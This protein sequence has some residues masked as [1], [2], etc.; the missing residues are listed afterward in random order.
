MGWF[1]NAVRRVGDFIGD[2]FTPSYDNSNESP[3]IDNGSLQYRINQETANTINKLNAANGID[4]RISGSDVAAAAAAYGITMPVVSTSTSKDTGAGADQETV[5]AYS[6]PTTTTTPSTT[7]PTTTTPE[8]FTYSFL[9]GEEKA[10]SFDEIIRSANN[11]YATGKAGLDRA[12]FYGLEFYANSKNPIYSSLAKD[13]L[14]FWGGS[15]DKIME[16]YYLHNPKSEKDT[17]P[18]YINY[19][20]SGAQSAYDA[21][22]KAI[23][24]QRAYAEK[25]AEQA[26]QEAIKNA[27]VNYDRSLSTYGQNAERLA[28]MGLSNSGYGDYL[29]GVAYSSMVGG[30]QDAHKTANEAVE[31]AY[32]NASQQKAEAADT[33]YERQAAERAEKAQ[34]FASI[35]SAVQS[36]GLSAEA[37][38]DILSLYEIGN[39]GSTTGNTAGST[40]GNNVFDIINKIEATNN[41]K[42]KT[43]AINALNLEI[44]GTA[45][46]DGNMYFPDEAAIRSAYG[47]YVDEETI[48]EYAEESEKNKSAYLYGV[49]ASQLTSK[50]T[51]ADID[52]LTDISTEHKT[53]LKADLDKLVVDSE[54]EKMRVE[55]ESGDV[56]LGNLDNIDILYNQK[57]LGINAYR[58]IYFEK[59]LSFAHGIENINE[60]DAAIGQINGYVNQGKITRE[61]AE[62]A[63][64]YIASVYATVVPENSYVLEGFYEESIKDTLVVNDERYGGIVS[65]QQQR[66]VKDDTIKKLI[67]FVLGNQEERG[68]VMIGDAIYTRWQAPTL[69]GGT[70]YLYRKLKDNH[71]VTEV[72]RELALTSARTP[73]KPTYI[74]VKEQ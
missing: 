24:E 51:Y 31:R 54:K 46:D 48:K 10:Y 14:A 73:I 63:K 68:F 3:V 58:E 41:E 43:E 17:P 64:E 16:N 67:D 45:G 62:K 35:Y 52:N 23:E 22:L 20:S 66:A 6:T 61:N 53:Q 72:L 47:K 56:N 8:V 34:L 37:A 11:A 7:T 25:L 29:N 28:Q 71:D 69:S 55:I 59:A 12:T 32:Y 39:V 15:H 26:R 44:K 13:A 27:Y 74:P 19:S 65:A 18:I 33:L 36:G 57:N 21:Q 40:T 70:E 38:E 2:L 4:S 1:K 60:Y 49:Y 50:T 9:G 30:V 42:A 5:V